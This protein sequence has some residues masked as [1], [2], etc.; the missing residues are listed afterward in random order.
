MKILILGSSGLLGNYLFNFLKKNF[1]VFNNGL[2]K[3]KINLLNIPELKLFLLRIKPDIIINC[4]ANTNLDNCEK[5]KGDAYDTNYKTLQNVVNLIKKYHIKSKIIQISTDQFYNNKNYKLNIESVNWIPNYYCKT[6]YLV[7]RFCI[8]NKI[9]V[10]RTNFFGKSNSKSKSFSDWIFKSFK[11]KK[12]FNLFHDI[13][14]SPLN[15]LTLSKMIKK[16]IINIEDINGIY[17]VG[18]RDCISK[19]EFAIKF[20]KSCI[21]YKKNYQSISAKGTFNAKKSNFMCMNIKKFEKKFK[22]KMPSVYSQIRYE[23][24]NYRLNK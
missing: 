9:V 10:L 23:A 18:S 16:V 7:E 21:I 5:K 13:Y 22:V 12:I 17:N 24:K 8:K 20:A 19:K 15:L 11:S 4:T 6:K 2:R 3:R 1:H 14:F